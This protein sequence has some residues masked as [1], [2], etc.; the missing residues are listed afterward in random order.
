MRMNEYNTPIQ[1]V[2][3]LLPSSIV[4]SSSVSTIGSPSTTIVA[5]SATATL[6]VRPGHL[7]RNS[8]GRVLLLVLGGARDGGEV[9]LLSRGNLGLLSDWG[10]SGRLPREGDY[11]RVLWWNA[12]E[13]LDYG[14]YITAHH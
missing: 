13:V 10:S 5:S 14:A 7:G 2:D 9:S 1:K 12:E 4:T 6:I 3:R 8:V 11:C